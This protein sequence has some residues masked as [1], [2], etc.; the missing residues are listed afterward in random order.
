[1]AYHEWGD[2]Q[3]PDVVLCVHGLTRTGRDFDLL[4]RSLG[5]RYRV[6]CPDVVGRG[7][8]DWLAHPS[9]Y[10]VP[11][12]VSDMVTLI[13]RLEPGRLHWVGTSMG[14]LIGMVYAGALAQSR[15]KVASRT[16]TQQHTAVPD[17]HLRLDSIVLNDVGPHL[18][19]VSLERIGHYVGESVQFSSFKDAVAYIRETCASFGPHRPEQWEELTRHVYIENNG[20]WVKHYDLSIGAA[21]KQMTPELTSQGE[22]LLWGAY[23]SIVAPIQIIRGEYSDLLSVQTCEKM[24]Q[25]QPH[26]RFAQV[27]GVGHAP[28]LM[29]PEQIALIHE[30]LISLG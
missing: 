15:L 29:S 10:A 3:N 5:T 8:S 22:S 9:Y 6:V 18:E 20:K 30:F 23:G 26:A 7:L 28:T 14:G 19:P 16:P 25:I 13:A 2:P 27:S 11:Q 12:Y 21:F 24:R 1:M 4:A 17:T